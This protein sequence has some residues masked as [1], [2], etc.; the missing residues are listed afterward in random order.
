MEGDKRRKSGCKSKS[1]EN[2]EQKMY[3]DL[4]LSEYDAF[5][6]RVLEFNKK[7]DA[8]FYETLKRLWDK[9]GFVITSEK[10][11]NNNYVISL[12]KREK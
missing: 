3:C 11:I 2:S 8:S 9:N 10:F 4:N 5:G 12:A 6:R 1:P 7:P